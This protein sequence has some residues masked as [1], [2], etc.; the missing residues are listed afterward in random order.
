MIL[1][2][3]NVYVCMYIKTVTQRHHYRLSRQVDCYEVSVSGVRRETSIGAEGTL[4]MLTGPMMNGV[5]ALAAGYTVC[6]LCICV[7][8]DC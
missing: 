3:K 4:A 1:L 8:Y 2:L 7:Y 6:S 5:C